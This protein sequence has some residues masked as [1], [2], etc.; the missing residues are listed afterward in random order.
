MLHRS[1]LKH[2][3]TAKIILKITNCGDADACCTLNLHSLV[4]LEEKAFV[5]QSVGHILAIDPTKANIEVQGII[6]HGTG[7]SFCNIS[8][9]YFYIAI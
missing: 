7:V 8:H 1:T 4:F 9:I 3:T 2:S 6:K 5:V